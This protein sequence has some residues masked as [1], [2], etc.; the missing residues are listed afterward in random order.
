MSLRSY[1]TCPFCRL[2]DCCLS[3]ILKQFSLF[4][5]SVLI[6]LSSSYFLK[7]SLFFSFT[8]SY[9]FAQHLNT[10][11]V[12]L[13]LYIHP[14]Y[15]SLSR[16]LLSFMF[17]WLSNLHLELG[18]HFWAHIFL[19]LLD[20]QE[21]DFVIFSVKMYLWHDSASYTSWKP[22]NNVILP[23]FTALHVLQSPKSVNFAV[24]I[25]L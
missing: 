12:L 16:T 25:A 23:F 5:D 14:S 7:C 6:P 17:W 13:S 21:T 11:L 9:S 24:L 2:C 19:C 4:S 8:D 1:L 22:S 10:C 20:P 18:S 15:I 3:S